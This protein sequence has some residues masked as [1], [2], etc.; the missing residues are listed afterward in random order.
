MDSENIQVCDLQQLRNTLIRQEETIIFALIERSQFA[1]NPTCYVKGAIPSTEKEVNDIL[2]N[3]TFLDYV[4]QQTEHVHAQ[5]RRYSSPD[6]NPFFP[7]SLPA[8]VIPAI[9]YPQNI[10]P[11]KINMNQ[12][13][14]E[15]YLHKILPLICTN[16]Q[17]DPTNYG[18]ATVC[19]TVVLQALSRRVHTGKH[20]AEVKF[21]GEERAMFEEA[22]KTRDADKL[23][24]AITHKAIE[25]RLLKRVRL[26]AMTYGQDITDMNEPPLNPTYKVQPE[27]I[28]NL[29]RDFIMP[30][31]KDVEVDYLLKRL[32]PC[33]VGYL[34]PPGTISMDAAQI[35]FANSDPV[36]FQPFTTIG[37]IVEAVLSGQLLCGVI[38]YYNFITGFIRE[39]VS[40]LLSTTVHVSGQ[41]NVPVDLNLVSNSPL[42]KIQ[43][44]C[45]HTTALEQCKQWL[46][47]YLPNV[48]ILEETSTATAAI[49]AKTEGTAAIASKTAAAMHDLKVLASGIQNFQ[50]NATRFLVVS[51]YYNKTPT[52]N[53]RTLLKFETTN[54]AGSLTTALNCFTQNNINLTSIESRPNPNNFGQKFLIEVEGHANDAAMKSALELLGTSCKSL[55][56]VGSFEN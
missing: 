1:L 25:E 9:N 49:K 12:K 45:S 15:M 44:V 16:H 37:Q 36:E 29:Y 8:P 20:V 22:I 53:N 27:I 48:Q 39:T 11:N 38:P 50:G 5:V 18:S 43:T 34:G 46:D 4:L 33:P 2:S 14:L 17:D 30:L 32:D 3:C 19:D 28:S 54:L 6:E 21:R 55:H 41:L 24:E 47:V 7:A 10:R 35:Y 26:K 51:K 52:G 23:L 31:T 42:N 56:I 40:L 13:I